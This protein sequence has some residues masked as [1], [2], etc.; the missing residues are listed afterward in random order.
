MIIIIAIIKIIRP[1]RDAGARPPHHEA[2]AQDAKVLLL[3]VGLLD[4][5]LAEEHEE[6]HD[7]NE[8]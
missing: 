4:A 7:D 3:L 8:H 1:D 2:D 5:R 6:D